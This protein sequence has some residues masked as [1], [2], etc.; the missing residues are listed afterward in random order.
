MRAEHGRQSVVWQGELERERPAVT[1]LKVEG[2]VDLLVEKHGHGVYLCRVIARGGTH[3]RYIDDD[4]SGYGHRFRG[5]EKHIA[6]DG[7]AG[8]Q[9]AN[10]QL[11]FHAR[12]IDLN[13][14]AGR[15]LDE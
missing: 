1:G 5:P 15:L 11:E 9:R 3:A 8:S 4:Q 7:V 6:G 12:P 14:V 2:L 10:R 13:R